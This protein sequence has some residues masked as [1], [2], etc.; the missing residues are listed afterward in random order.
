[1]RKQNFWR[2]F[3]AFSVSVCIFLF[4]SFAFAGEPKY[5]GTLRIGTRVPQFNRLDALQLTTETMVPS[6]TMIYDYLFNWGERGLESMTPALATSYETKDNKVWIFH[7][8]KGVKFHNGREMTA[9][10]IKANFDC[11]IT[12][13][14]GWRPVKYREL[15]KYLKKAEVI[16]RYTVKITLE[17]PFAPLM[18]ILAWCMRAIAPL[19][20]VEKWRDKFT[21]H[22]V[23]TGPFK[24]VEMKPKEKVV[25]E[26]FDDYWGPKPYVDRVVYKYYRSNQARLIALQ[27]GE[28]DIAPLFDEAKPILDKDPN[29]SYE[30]LIIPVVLHKM[31]FNMRRWPMN[32]LRF[33]RAVLM[34]ADWK[35][36]VINTFAFKSG[37]YARTPFEYS[38][39][40][41]PEALELVPPYS[42]EE[43]KK[44]IQAVEKDA[45]KKI[46]PIY[47]LDSTWPPGKNTAEAAKAQLA[48]IGVPLNL[49]LL[50]HA[51]W[52]DKILRDPKIEWDIAGYGQ[53]FGISAAQGLRFFE[54]D[55]ATAPDGKSLGGYSNPEFD[56]WILK[57]EAAKT[58][59]ERIKCYQEAEKILIKD[60]AVLP[61][62]AYRMLIAYNNK[63]VKDLKA[64]NTG[65]IYV[66]NTWANV[67]LEQ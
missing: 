56:Q 20:E 33:R 27:K 38:K 49:Q 32:D 59:K 34:G 22:P 13:P 35:N 21:L 66:T 54:T 37:N 47:W 43:A 50:S 57:S 45:G 12:T 17:R 16:D 61:L 25:L 7:L 60:A 62:F 10:D 15:I 3:L 67:W 14:K 30:E 40:F 29:L 31:F 46:P 42:P 5:G 58:E 18:P 64:T 26:R 51:I 48:Q 24:V 8:R 2:I 41:N 4:S 63:K 53:A 65:N 36:I 52:F 19:E 9:E 11:R 23:G 39:Y 28:L 44:L 55:S 6:A 1:M